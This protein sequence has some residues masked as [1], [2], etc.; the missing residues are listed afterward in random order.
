MER[1]H[2]FQWFF[3][4]IKKSSVIKSEES[5]LE[6]FFSFFHVPV[7]FEHSDFDFLENKRSSDI[8]TDD[9]NS[10]LLRFDPLLGVPVPVITAA[11]TKLSATIEEETNNSNCFGAGAGVEEQ[12]GDCAMTNVDMK[13]ENMSDIKTSL[14]DKQDYKMAELDKKMKNEQ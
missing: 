2:F 8:L 6:I 11:A 12:I 7:T 14:D 4:P 3:A 13:I 5:Y 10:I 9:R 1:K